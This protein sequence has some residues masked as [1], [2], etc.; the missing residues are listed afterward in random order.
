MNRNIPFAKPKINYP[1][2]GILILFTV[3]CALNIPIL[4]TLWRHGFDDGTYSHAFLIP[5]ISLYLYYELA[6]SGKLQFREAFSIIPA[7]L[8][9]FSCYLLFI[10]S[11]AQ[12]SI[13]YWGAFL[14]VLITSVTML[15]RFNWYI[16]F[17]AAFL[18]FIFP[19]WGGITTTLQG[20]SVFAV[21]L[22]M[23]FTSVPTY[24][25]AQYVSIPSGTFEIAHGCS[26][27]RYLIVSLAISSLYIFL[28]IKSF[29]KAALFFSIAILGGLLTNW[30]RITILILIGDYTNMTHSLMNDHNNFGWY[31][32]MP[33]M[34]LLF[35]LGGAL[36]KSVTKTNIQNTVKKSSQVNKFCILALICS[37]SLSSTTIPSLVT[38]KKP[39]NF[40]TA[41]NFPK[42]MYFYS[43]SEI[44]LNNTLILKYQFN[45][46]DLDSKPTFYDNNL[47]PKGW[48]T[49]SKKNKD[50]IYQAHI[51]N[52]SQQAIIQIFYKLNNSTFGDAKQFKLERLKL[53]VLGQK[54]NIALYWSMTP[55]GN[56]C[57]DTELYS[58][59]DLIMKF[60]ANEET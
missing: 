50:N 58:P 44:K 24:V 30:L 19:F 43:V 54:N 5:F 1:F 3:I 28:N 40:I 17:P 4:I 8:L 10:T 2:L 59:E 6:Q 57:S 35:I 34:L 52:G 25:E 14:A 21:T 29:W 22:L 16:V 36:S 38:N 31:V 53:G 12:I 41:V 48:S 33:F 46:A 47:L 7:I 18:V 23:S 56:R 49:V 51:S 13:G 60:K 39:V 20:I 42:I 15:Y 45:Q 37:L 32:Y 11:N 55:C 27:L 26:G 9:L